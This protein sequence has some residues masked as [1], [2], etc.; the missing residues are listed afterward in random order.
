M[1]HLREF[2]WK[3]LGISKKHIQ[4]VVDNHYLK[5]DA[6]TSIGYKTYDNNAI[7]Y[8]WSDAPLKIGK[9]CS[10]SYGVKFILD[11]GKHSYNV[12]SNYPF[13]TNEVLYTKGIFVGHDVWIGMDS[14]I[15]PGVTIGNGVTIAA[16]SVITKDVP[17]YCVVAGVPARIIREKCTDREKLA[18]NTIAW[19]D[20]ED[21]VIKQRMVDFKLNIPDFIK[22]YGKA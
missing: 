4:W 12:V 13:H 16:G 2:L 3:L 6:Y 8:R 17:D 11:D 5:E 9:Y 18:M 1:E 7:I 22:K 10:L 20:W 19:W 15:L 14:I 21:E